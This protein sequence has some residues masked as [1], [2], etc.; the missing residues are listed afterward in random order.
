METQNSLCKTAPILITGSAGFIGRN[1]KARLLALG[2]ENLLCYDVHSREEDLRGYAQQAAFVFH[3]AGINRPQ[4]P[5]EFYSGNSALTQRLLGYL[6]EAN[7]QTPVLLSS[8][9]QVGNGSD[10]AKSKETAENAVF[11]HGQ[12]QNSPVFVFRLPGVFGKW[13]RPAYN[14]VVATFCHNIANGKDIE[15]HN[16]NHGLTLCYIDDVVHCFLAAMQGAPVEQ[17][18]LGFCQVSPVHEITLGALAATIQDF[19]TMRLRL[20]TPQMDD[21]LQKKLYA[22]Y[23]S[24]LPQDA[25]SYTLDAKTD[26]RGSFTEFLR[27]PDRGQISVNVAKPGIVKGNHWHDTKHE[28]FYVVSG[29]AAIRFRKLFETE[30]IEYIVSGDTPTPVS[31]P[32]GYTHNIENLGEHDLVTLMWASEAFDAAN[33]DTYFEEV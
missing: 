2:F 19:S 32:P 18:A 27:T 10:Y 4:D 22:C 24:Y 8:S 28:I 33:P 7:S 14:S 1:L 23:L 6:Q 12:E 30:V 31:I 5:A 20:Q 26:A 17:D 9:A 25:F 11:L 21:A 3:L 16:A 29:K 13:C 15:V